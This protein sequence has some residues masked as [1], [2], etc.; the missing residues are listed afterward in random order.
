MHCFARFESIFPICAV[1]RGQC[2]QSSDGDWADV[3]GMLGQV[4]VKSERNQTPFIL[5]FDVRMLGIPSMHQCMMATEFFSMREKL[6]EQLL[7]K[8]YFLASPLSALV[9]DVCTQLRQPKRPIALSHMLSSLWS[10]IHGD[11]FLRL[12]EERLL[13][14]SFSMNG[15]SG[16]DVIM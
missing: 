11:G 14:Q 7:L 16:A 1:V 5:V 4:Y 2:T 15:A 10:N 3:M 12:A 8:V 6:S 9:L 13:Q